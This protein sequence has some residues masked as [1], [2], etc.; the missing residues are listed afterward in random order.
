MII[1]E[2]LHEGCFADY[3]KAAVNFFARENG[4][5]ALA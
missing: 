2:R 5:E 1:I 3:V 4:I